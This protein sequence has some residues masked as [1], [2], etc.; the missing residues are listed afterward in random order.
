MQR[1]ACLLTYLVLAACHTPEPNAEPQTKPSSETPTSPP[2]VAPASTRVHTIALERSP[3]KSRLTEIVLD[4]RAEAALTLEDSGEVRLWPSLA[5]DQIEK[6]SPWHLRL[7]D[8][9]WMS[10]ARARESGGFTIGVIDTTNAAQIVELVIGTPPGE[11]RLE[12]RFAIPPTDP[13]LELLVLDGGERILALGVDHRLRL[14]DLD[15]RLLSQLDERSFAPWQLRSSGGDGSEPLHLAVILTAPLRIEQIE[16]V[17]DQLRRSAKPWPVELDRGPNRNDLA[18]TA[19]GRHAAALRRH[20]ATGREWSVELIDLETGERKLLAGRLDTPV[21]ARMHMLPRVGGVAR[22][23]LES[24]SGRGHVVSLDQAVALRRDQDADPDSNFALAL[25]RSTEHPFIEIAAAA[26]DIALLPDID[27]GLRMHA[28]VV[29][30]VRAS[31]D[32]SGKIEILTLD[33]QP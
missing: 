28:S 13:L 33:D 4:P 16:I 6:A 21:R 18:L 10:L 29:G 30:R 25:A 23:L 22:L 5:P 3:A 27:T 24:G 17:E 20:Q 2:E 11:A 15:G 26:E 31:M 19:D 1:L 7:Q 8:P 14:Y 12:P 9:I 32:Q